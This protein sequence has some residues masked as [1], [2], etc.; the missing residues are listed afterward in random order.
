MHIRFDTRAENEISLSEER[1]E[2]YGVTQLIHS[3][4]KFNMHIKPYRDSC[5]PPKFNS[6]WNEN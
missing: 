6:T 1:A 2:I 5:V 4:L 3:L